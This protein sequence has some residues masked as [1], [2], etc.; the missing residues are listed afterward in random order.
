[1]KTQLFSMDQTLIEATNLVISSPK[2]F[3]WNKGLTGKVAYS[4]LPVVKQ[5]F[6]D[7]FLGSD[8][9]MGILV[10]FLKGY[11][12]S[13]TNAVKNNVITNLFKSLRKSKFT[14]QHPSGY[15]YQHAA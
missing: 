15:N 7:N 4:L 8:M 5:L 2:G 11:L 1:M 13:A 12:S 6:R 14:P 3:K 9:E 10:I